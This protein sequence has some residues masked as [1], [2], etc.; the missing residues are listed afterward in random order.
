M[1]NQNEIENALLT[2]AKYAEGVMLREKTSTTYAKT[3]Y[4]GLA[5]DV[6]IAGKITNELNEAPEGKVRILKAITPY[7]T[8]GYVMA[9]IEEYEKIS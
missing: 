3:F 9:I 2:L 7:G 8:K 6:S 1:E 5:C 4:D